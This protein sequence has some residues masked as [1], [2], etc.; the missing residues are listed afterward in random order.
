MVVLA[1]PDAD[2]IPETD[3][4][5]KSKKESRKALFFYSCANDLLYPFFVSLYL[6]FIMRSNVI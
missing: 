5:V 1:I 3:G 2:T 4:N 6:S